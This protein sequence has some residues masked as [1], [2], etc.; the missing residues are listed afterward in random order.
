MV[1]DVALGAALNAVG[2]LV[3]ERALADR[4]A[5]RDLADEIGGK[6]RWAAHHRR[7]ARRHRAAVWRAGAG[8]PGGGAPSVVVARDASV[9]FE[10]NRDGLLP[11]LIGQTVIVRRR[12]KPGSLL[13]D[14]RGVSR[15]CAA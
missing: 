3:L 5:R 8:L 10:G 9:A 15:Q 1:L 13:E 14:R 11:S 12:S 4:K 2:P 6:S 7:R